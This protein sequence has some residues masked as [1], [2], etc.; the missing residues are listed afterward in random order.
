MTNEGK[1]VEVL[2]GMFETRIDEIE[3]IIEALD[4]IDRDYLWEADQNDISEAIDALTDAVRCAKKEYRS[5]R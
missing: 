3:Q 2:I 5:R 4:E 1:I